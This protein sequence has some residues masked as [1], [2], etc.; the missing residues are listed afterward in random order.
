MTKE[1]PVIGGQAVIEGVMMRSPKFLTIALR[2]P[3]GDI[4][5]RKDPYIAITK[6]NRWLN[7]PILRGAIVLVESMYLGIKALTFSAD[8]AMEEKVMEATDQAEHEIESKGKAFGTLWLILIVVLGLGLGVGLFFYLPLIITD[9]LGV[10]GGILFN[11]VD[12]M[13]RI[14]IFLIYIWAIGLWKETRRIFEYH[15]AEHKSIATFEMGEELTVNN[16]KKHTTVH[17]RCGTSFL[18]VVMM[19]SMGIFIFLGRP[20][21]ITE[22]LM[23]FLF[24]PLIG[25]ISYEIIKASSR[26]NSNRFI[27]LLIKPGLWL[28]KLTTR[29]PNSDQL[30][31]AIV[32]LKEALEK[33]KASPKVLDS[34]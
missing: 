15:G 27:Q 12:G 19:V 17:A 23:R 20:T 16:A 21:T 18:V 10:R 24:I 3:D 2:K 14:G 4:L 29:E 8:Q 25:G 32:A 13:L 26:H 30:E 34:I 33:S 5:V 28:Q 22:R 9:F 1:D 31:V 7:I 11:L 6:R